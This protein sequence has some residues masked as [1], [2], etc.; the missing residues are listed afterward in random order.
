MSN[1]VANAAA[2]DPYAAL[3]GAAADGNVGKAKA[4]SAESFLTMLV[5]QMQ[6]QDPLNPMDNAQITSQM[7]QINTVTGLEKVNE[8]IKALGTQFAQMQLLQGAALVGREVTLDGDTVTFAGGR[9]RG[10]FD[11]ASAAGAVKVEVLDGGGQVVDTVD[12]GR[13][14][15]GRA[16]FEWDPGSRPTDAAYGFRVVAASDGRAVD[17]RTLSVARVQSISTTGGSLSLTLER[18]GKVAAADVVGFN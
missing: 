4:G 14:D 13:R 5:T 2:T 3:R 7:A 12:L 16:G 17:A 9:G 1:A 15:A 6:N 18:F 10:A 8:S 11:L